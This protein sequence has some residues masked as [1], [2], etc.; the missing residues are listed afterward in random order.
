MGKSSLVN[1]FLGQ[2]RVIVSDT[3]G[4]TRDAIDTRLELDGRPLV[5][6]D[7]A[8]LRRRTKV[9][10]TVAFYAQLRSERAARRADVAI[11]VCDASE[12]LTSEDLRIAD[13]AMRSGCATVLA[14]NKWDVGR[15]DLDH[16]TA[17]AR[18]K[19]RLRPR[20]LTASALTGRGVTR[21]LTE[22]AALAD[23]AAVRIPT[24]ELNRFLGDV[25]ATREPPTVRGRRLRLYYMTQYDTRPPRFA[26]QV[27]D[28]ARV[29]RDYAFFL[30]NRLRERWELEGVPL[31][32]DFKGRAD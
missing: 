24:A 15:T 29:T 18:R 23:R 1:A 19:L 2:E 16:A 8:G 27:S 5:L 22:A 17:R 13:L 20:I 31:V 30:E 11:V 32:I 21:L 14:L 7:T 3:A 6:V 12:G 10:G 9:A 25:Q 26:I 4:T 28:R